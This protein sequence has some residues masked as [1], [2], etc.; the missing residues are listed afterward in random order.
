MSESQKNVTYNCQSRAYVVRP[1]GGDA[2]SKIVS[3]AY[4]L[5]DLLGHD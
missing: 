5:G 3:S 2:Q 1:V 4:Q